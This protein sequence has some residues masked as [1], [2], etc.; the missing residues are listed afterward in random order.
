M[1]ISVVTV[2]LNDRSGLE[3][4]R[5]SVKKQLGVEIEHI[6][7]DGASSDGTAELALEYCKDQDIPSIVR[8]EKDHGLYDAMNKGVEL[9]TG[10]YISFLNAGDYF[11][12]SDV[13]ST[14]VA[15]LDGTP[16]ICLLYGSCYE[17]R[18]D[19]QLTHKIPRGHG[20]VKSGMF[21]N[22]Q[23]MFFN[24]GFIVKNNI[25]Y[26]INYKIGGDYAYCS[27][28]IKLGGIVKYLNIPICVFEMSGISN[29]RKSMGRADNWRIQRDILGVCFV[30]RLFNQARYLI[31]AYLSDV[32]PSLYARIRYEREN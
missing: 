4:T 18:N 32:A 21:A 5:N 2:V 16:G 7:V 31:S 13:L 3:K 8:S 17:L 19:G 24:R 22:H 30:E 6:I 14:V 26:D 29:T 12:E 20:K 10:D 28:L 9:A 27:K 23:A 11:T 25:K 15:E 1:K